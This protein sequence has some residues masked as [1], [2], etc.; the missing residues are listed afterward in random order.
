VTRN[1][2]ITKA[3]VDERPPLPIDRIPDTN[4]S[5]LINGTGSGPSGS[6]RLPYTQR[7]IAKRRR[8]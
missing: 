2:E 5:A 6:A 1:S 8:R 7:E 4:S 3:T